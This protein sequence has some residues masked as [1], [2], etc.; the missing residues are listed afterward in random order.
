MPGIRTLFAPGHTPGHMA[1]VVTSQ[2][3]VKRL[4]PKDQLFHPVFGSEGQLAVEEFKAL[5]KLDSELAEKLEILLEALDEGGYVREDPVTAPGQMAR[6][7]GILD[8]FPS[9][10]EEPVRI[11]FFG[12]TVFGLRGFDP[13]T[14]RATRP[15]DSIV[16]LPLADIFATRSVVKALVPLLEQRFAGRRELDALL[17]ARYTDGRRLSGIAKNDNNFSLQLLDTNDRLQLFTSDELAKVTYGRESLMPSNYGK[18]LTSDEF[19]DLMAFLSR[20]DGGPI[21]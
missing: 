3:E 6:R 2:G 10:R 21:S 7:G 14:Q 4:T 11:E 17:E 20:R 12:D 19:Q 9:E 5:E 1:V 8:V 15:L 13:E 16:T 18:V